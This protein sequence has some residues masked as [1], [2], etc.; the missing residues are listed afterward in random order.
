MQ[1]GK[2]P[3]FLFASLSYSA[4]F[5]GIFSLSGSVQNR[6][7]PKQFEFAIIIQGLP[8]CLQLLVRV[9]VWVQSKLEV[10]TLVSI[11]TGKLHCLAV[12]SNGLCHTLA[13]TELKQ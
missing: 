8:Q 6:Q 10:I 1:L 12:F 9:D 13:N 2:F 4:E 7:Y 5:T 11:M 3:S